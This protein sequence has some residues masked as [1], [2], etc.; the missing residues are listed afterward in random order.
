M[1]TRIEPDLLSTET[2]P[3][4]PLRA[5]KERQGRRRRIVLGVLVLAAVLVGWWGYGKWSYSRAHA[6][7]DNAQVDG[8]ILPMLSRVSGYVQSVRV[9][10]N[11]HVRAGD[12]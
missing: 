6:S 8:T 3:S 1:A 2:M 11:D 7:T 5:I 4:A 9:R 12:T 10:E